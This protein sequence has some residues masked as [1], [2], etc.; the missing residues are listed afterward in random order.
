[1]YPSDSNSYCNS[2][3][4]DG[5]HPVWA[6][7]LRDSGYTCRA[8]GKLDLNDDFDTGFE[9]VPAGGGHRHHPDI[10]SLFRRPP[11][12]RIGERE[13]VDGKPRK[14]RH[15]DEKNANAAINFIKSPGDA[16][17]VHW[18]GFNQPH[19]PFAGLQEHVDLYPVD[20]IDLPAKD[21]EEIHLVYQALRHFKR[22]A[23]PIPEDRI[24][25][26]RAGYYAMITELDEYVGRLIDTVETSGQLDNTIV[27]YTSDHGEMLGE[28]GLWY[29]N[30]LYE[31]AA[32]VPLVVAGPNI[33]AGARVIDVISHVDLVATLADWA[34]ATPSTDLR[35][36][37]LSPLLGGSGQHRGSVYVESHSEGNVTGSHMIRKGDW[38]YIQ[39]TYYEPLLFNL[40]E[41]PGETRNRAGDPD[42][43]PILRE[44]DLLLRSIVDPEVL[45]RRAFEAQD[46]KLAEIAAGKSE[47]E[48]TAILQS[49]L[50]PG[51]ARIMAQAT[52]SRL[53]N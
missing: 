34:E 39:F 14:N 32:H 38:K 44:L 27:I 52:L 22:V 30:N 25:R 48:L 33:P 2:T 16:P 23:A 11:I 47:K 3:V 21:P 51:L 50:G 40:R 35:G 29:K 6:T 8:A 13:T 49:R 9:D 28:H 41:D 15:S 42:S 26:A 12:Y 37:S 7:W 20:D 45:T 1:M 24:R 10:T 53:Q 36:L 46:C 5:S 31:D 4:W 18:V 19:S 43:Q 17:W